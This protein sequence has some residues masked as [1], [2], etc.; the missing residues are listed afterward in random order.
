MRPAQHLCGAR[1]VRGGVTTLVL[2]ACLALSACA[3]HEPPPP[4]TQAAQTVAAGAPVAEALPSWQDGAA[5]A[6][7]LGFIADVTQD[8]G[9]RYVPPESRIAVFDNDGTL[10]SEQPVPFQVAFMLDQLKK[11]AP[12]HP[13][14]QR[15]PAFKALM[16]HDTA[17]LAKNEKALL[18]LL[19]VANSGMTTEAYDQ[20]IRTW[21]ASAKHP[22]L[23]RPFTELVYQPQLELLDLLRANGFTVWIVSGGTAEFMRVW[24]DKVYGIAPEH[25]VGSEEK[26]KY[27]VREGKPVLIREPGFDFWDDGANK[28]VGIF[29]ALGRR[30]ILAFGNSDGDRQMLEYVTGGDGPSLGLLLHHDDAAREFAYDR[31]A[32]SASLDKAWDEAGARGW[33]IVS[34]KQD[35][36][37]VYPA[38][39]AGAK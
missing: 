17:A 26:L 18:Q 32:G 22:T 37:A 2:C 13:E 27:E 33:V 5:R 12:Q 23:N 8:G 20:S 21:L 19:E 34:M 38:P 25:I 14:W 10:W 28:P 16:A 9:P 7:I 1:S 30:P 3:S 4:T 11:A 29:R 15:N 39:G 36:K 35:W 6:A 24:A 31:H